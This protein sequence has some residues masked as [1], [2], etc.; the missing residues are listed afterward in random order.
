[1]RLETLTPQRALLAERIV[2]AWRKPLL[3]L[4]L[5]WAGL[6]ALFAPDWAAMVQQWWDSS[7]YNHILVVPAILA[8]LVWQRVH[9][10]AKLA[11]KAWWPGLVLL[12][13]GLFVWLLGD[14]SGTATASHL[15]LV[16]SLQA[17]TIA[18]LGPR[19]AWALLFP[20]A[21]GF[22]LVPVG[23]ELVPALQMI[24]AEIT[25]ALTHASG[26]PALIDGV[27]IDTPVGL[28]EVAEACSGVKFLVAMAALGTLVAHVCYRS[29][30]R[31]AA[32]MTVAIVLPILANGVRAWGTIY[33]AQSQGLEF[34]AGFDHVF[35]GWI[36]FALVM[37]ALLGLGWRFFDRGF[38]EE[39]IDGA[40]IGRL[41]W[42]SRLERWSG[43]GWP[44]LAGLALLAVAVQGW[45]QAARGVE[46]DMPAV[47][48]LPEVPGWTRVT[49]APAHPWLPHTSGADHKLIASFADGEGRVVD[50]VLALYAAQEDGR[51][52]TGY[53][54]GALPS[55]SA[56]RWLSEAPRVDGAIGDRLQALGTYQR[57][58]YTWYRHGDWTGSSRARLKLA[59]MADRLLFA[60]QPT[61]MLIL[62]A[63]DNERQH[64]ESTLAAFR[65]STAPLPEWMDAVAMLD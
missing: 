20:L 57:V 24:T 43:A 4:A 6:F 21:Y 32:F 55:D 46:A 8:W 18:M 58:A 26:I 42:L 59:N 23:D 64:A 52:A 35:Y 44:V 7:T 63:E 2:P 10:L 54:E 39:F 11:P 40:A 51:E 38:D 22:F 56:W 53:G 15:G 13:G 45:A 49:P 34:A 37:A 19:L 60:P 61:I 27:F 14:I 36:F 28:F 1:M 5:A 62:S 12:F 33:I 29:W 41:G 31:R 65:Q 17:V 48:D 9:Q 16:L 50:V 25:I 3:Q 30:I 47:I